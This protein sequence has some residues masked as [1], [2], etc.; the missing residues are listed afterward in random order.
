MASTS[1]NESEETPDKGSV[2]SSEPEEASTPTS[3]PPTTTTWQAIFA[4]Q[5]NTYYFYNPLTQETT[6]I[7]PLQQHT[8]T[9]TQAQ[10]QNENENENESENKEEQDTAAQGTSATASAAS[11]RYAALQAAAV[12][13][14]ID[15]LLAHLDPSLASPSVPGSSSG[16]SGMF[17]TWLL[18]G[19]LTDYI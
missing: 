18:N 10:V 19:Y 5:Y 16:T 2:P 11:A 8:D 9:Q 15:P 4:P 3:T 17:C 14:G 1:R 6:W 12:A 13:Q 7:N